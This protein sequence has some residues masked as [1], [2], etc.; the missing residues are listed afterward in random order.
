[1]IT[2]VKLP[3]ETVNDLAVEVGHWHV[4]DMSRVA[5]DQ[6][7][8]EVETSKVNVA[9]HS[10]ASGYIIRMATEGQVLSVGSIV[11]KIYSDLAELQSNIESDVPSDSTLPHAEFASGTR[12]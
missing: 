10:P 8:L 1:M 2:A 3:L 5:S 11:A 4:D 9:I 7:L 6:L 12:F